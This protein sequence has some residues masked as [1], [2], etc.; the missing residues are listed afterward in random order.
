MTRL[1]LSAMPL[2]WTLVLL[3]HGNVYAHQFA[4]QGSSQIPFWAHSEGA[5]D[6]IDLST[7]DSGGIGTYA[8]V[9]YEN[10][11]VESNSSE[12]FDIAILG[13]PFDTVCTI[14]QEH[15]NSH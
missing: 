1:L 5:V 11:F 2:T 3:L 10:C 6:G 12:G 13:A 7:Y 14:C 8:G 15:E 9:A 4:P